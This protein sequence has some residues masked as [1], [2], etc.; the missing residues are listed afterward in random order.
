[1]NAR[2]LLDASLDAAIDALGPLDLELSTLLGRAADEVRARPYLFFALHDESDVPAREEVAL[3]GV[4]T[5][6]LWVM[7][8][9]LHPWQGGGDA[10]VGRHLL[11]VLLTREA[12]LVRLVRAPTRALLRHE[13]ISSLHPVPPHAGIVAAGPPSPDLPHLVDRWEAQHR[14]PQPFGTLLREKTRQH[15]LFYRAFLTAPLYAYR[16]ARI[17]RELPPEIRANDVMLETFS[18]LEQLGPVLDNFVLGSSSAPF[19]A[20]PAAIADLAFLYMQLADEAVDSILHATSP[21]AVRALVERLAAREGDSEALAPFTRVSA[22]DLAEI[23][24]DRNLEVQKYGASLGE[25]LDAIDALGRS[26]E[27]CI[28]TLAEPRRAPI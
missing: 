10:S 23:D 5:L 9:A 12:E 1:M 27:A 2:G 7:H 15:F 28:A 16:R 6:R 25:L 21:E 26:I 3:A 8:H 17:R 20:R 4:L 22:E 11:E 14:E 13:T 18:A 24:L 19:R